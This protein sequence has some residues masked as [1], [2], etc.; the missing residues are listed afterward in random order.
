ML[1]SP[2]SVVHCR[3]NGTYHRSSP[4]CPVSNRK[5][6]WPTHHDSLH[7]VPVHTWKTQSAT[8]IHIASPTRTATISYATTYR[9][10]SKMINKC[11]GGKN[12]AHIFG[13]CGLCSQSIHEWCDVALEILWSKRIVWDN[14]Q[15]RFDDARRWFA[16][17][18]CVCIN[19]SGKRIILNA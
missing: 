3:W 4:A 7:T 6:C 19:R 11:F 15:R 9:C 14:H 16:V 10:N 1:N 18:G 17:C 8:F 12:I 2:K 5:D 13:T